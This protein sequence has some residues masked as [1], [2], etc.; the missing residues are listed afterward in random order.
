MTTMATSHHSGS[1]GPRTLAET[2]ETHA[3]TAS[4]MWSDFNDLDFHALI[5]VKRGR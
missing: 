3:I 2:L 5:D 1:F 4:L